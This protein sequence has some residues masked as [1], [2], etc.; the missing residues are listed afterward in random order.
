[1]AAAPR[2]PS[3]YATTPA[4]PPPA[5][6]AVKPVCTGPHVTFQANYPRF[7]ASL[8]GAA[9][10]APLAD[11]WHSL[12][13]A[14]ANNNGGLRCAALNND[15]WLEFG[16]WTGSTIALIARFRERYHGQRPSGQPAVFGFDSFQGLPEDWRVMRLHNRTG[17]RNGSNFAKGSFALRNA[18][19]PRL[20]NVPAGAVEW[21]VGWFNETLPPFLAAHD[22]NVSFLHIDCDLYSSTKSVLQALNAHSSPRLHAGAVI[23]E[24]SPEMQHLPRRHA[25]AD[26]RAMPAPYHDARSARRSPV[27][28]TCSCATAA[29]QLRSVR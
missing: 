5:L 9:R 13:G 27:C 29:S 8:I 3:A 20:H 7:M 10:R 16:V 15:L 28:P 2:P 12:I 6:P 25:R 19:P 4:P 1:M 22:G 23:G 18:K 11:P 21:I 24:S 17:V 26:A 14:R